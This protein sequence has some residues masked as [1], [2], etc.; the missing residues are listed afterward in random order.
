M[1]REGRIDLTEQ[2]IEELI[3]SVRIHIDGL[4]AKEGEL[5]IFL[6]KYVANKKNLALHYDP[7]D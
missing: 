2:R 5:M 1:A 3:Q 6:S 4:T 7:Q